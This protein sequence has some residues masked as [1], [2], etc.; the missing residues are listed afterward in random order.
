MV[1]VKDLEWGSD[2]SSE[3]ERHRVRQ[4]REAGRERRSHGQRSERRDRT[5]VLGAHLTTKMIK[6]RRAASWTMGSKMA[7]F[8][9][10]SVL[11]RDTS[12][13]SGCPSATE[14]SVAS[15]C[16]S[17]GEEKVWS[18]WTPGLGGGRVGDA[19]SSR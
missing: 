15:F 9:E 19:P 18:A 11:I 6:E 3:V 16:S 1:D 4:R 5:A 12:D 2:E 10:R 7:A 17:Q 8:S 13:A 14:Q